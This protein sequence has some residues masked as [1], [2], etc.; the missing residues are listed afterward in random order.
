M[1]K[2]VSLLLVFAMVLSFT[3]CGG[4]GQNTAGAADAQSDTGAKTE[5]KPAQKATEW[6]PSKENSYEYEN[7]QVLLENE[8]VR[9]TATGL[10]NSMS[11]KGMRFA[12]NMKMENLSDNSFRIRFYRNGKDRQSWAAKLDPKKSKERGL[13]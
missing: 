8:S 2:A 13:P 1:K 9:F 10:A 12:V 6:D 4:S 5:A 11:D 3:A 7:G